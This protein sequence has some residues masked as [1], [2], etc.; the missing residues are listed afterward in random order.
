MS[1]FPKTN[2][3][4]PPKSPDSLPSTSPLMMVETAFLASAA[5]LIWFV[6]YYFPLGPLLRVFF[7]LPIAL[8]YL[9]WNRRAANMGALTSGLLLTVLMGPTRSVL[10][11]IPYAWMGVVLGGLWKRGARWPISVAIGALIGAIG[12]FFRYWLLSILLGRD[13]WVYAT[14]Q[15]AELAEWIFIKLGLLAPPSLLFVQLVAVLMVFANSIVYL[16]VVHLV[17][18][19]MLDRLKSPIPR[20][21][22]WVQILLDYDE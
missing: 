1:D 20:P 11:L 6:N 5:S 13:L 14:T 8:L 4:S 10:F 3:D 15:I 12:F 22:R 7:P 18:L 2:A 17:A 16:F 21:P 9:R 19:L